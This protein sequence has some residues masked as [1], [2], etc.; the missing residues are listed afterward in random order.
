MKICFLVYTTKAIEQLE[1]T[2]RNSRGDLAA[3]F[4]IQRKKFLYQFKILRE[5]CLKSDNSRI[6]PASAV[7]AKNRSWHEHLWPRVHLKRQ[8][9]ARRAIYSIIHLDKDKDH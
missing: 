5:N 4:K 9:E 2:T 3:K 6:K 8:K 1:S 7:E